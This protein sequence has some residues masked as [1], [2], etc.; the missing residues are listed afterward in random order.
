MWLSFTKLLRLFSDNLP[1]V[2]FYCLKVRNSRF[3]P[4]LVIESSRSSGGYVLGFKIDPEDRLGDILKQ[5]LAYYETYYKK[6]QL[7]VEYVL[8]SGTAATGEE[9]K[10]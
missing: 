5:L 4:A 3:G 9:T 8:E 7:G 10:G 6:P 2:F 1:A